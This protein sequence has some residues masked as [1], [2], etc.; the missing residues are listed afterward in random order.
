[1]GSHFEEM[2]DI[3][4]LC[5]SLHPQFAMSQNNSRERKQPQDTWSSQTAC[6]SVQN[7]MIFF[8]FHLLERSLT[9]PSLMFE[10]NQGKTEAL[11]ST[12]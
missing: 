2:I 8:F 7:T 1:M 10:E 5:F 4:L 11:V 12:L 6:D 3:G 9:N